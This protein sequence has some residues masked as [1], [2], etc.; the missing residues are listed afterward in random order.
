[1]QHNTC[2][3]S[4][5]SVSLTPLKRITACRWRT[6]VRWKCLLSVLLAQLLP[7]KDLHKVS[8]DLCL[9]FRIS[10]ASTWTQ[11]SR[12]SNVLKSWTTLEMQ[13]ILPRILPK[14][15]LQRHLC[16]VNFYGIFIPRMAEKLNPFY[17]LLKAE[18][19]INIT[20]ERI[21]TLDS[22]NKS[23]KDACELILKQSI[24][25]KQS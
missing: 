7:T 5:Y 16:F 17:K 1:M 10:C 6:N 13:P 12:L 2:Q 24:P 15:A 11:L 8:A 9:L 14:N 18:V 19:P 22:V 21:E 3:G 4:H 25:G 23:L 20:L